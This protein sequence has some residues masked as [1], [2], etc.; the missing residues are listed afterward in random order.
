MIVK[1]TAILEHNCRD[2]LFQGHENNHGFY[3]PWTAFMLEKD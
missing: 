3:I 2:L 1:I